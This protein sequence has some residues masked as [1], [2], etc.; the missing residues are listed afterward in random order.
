[1]SDTVHWDRVAA[2]LQRD[3]HRMIWRPYG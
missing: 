3:Q 2:G 1:M